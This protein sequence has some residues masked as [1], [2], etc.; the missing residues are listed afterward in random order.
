MQCTAHS[1]CSANSASTDI[2]SSAPSAFPR[3]QPQLLRKE[4]K[5]LITFV[6]LRLFLKYIQ[7][8]QIKAVPRVGSQVEVR[9]GDVR[10]LQWEQA[11]GEREAGS[12]ASSPLNATAS[13]QQLGDSLTLANKGYMY[14]SGPR[15]L[16]CLGP[17]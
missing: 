15:A 7:L 11:W 16:L 14:P 6:Q 2:P 8:R 5:D 1:R 12:W 10:L 3:A 13:C 4:D 9:A 17:G